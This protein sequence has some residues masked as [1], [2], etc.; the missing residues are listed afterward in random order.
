MCV[1]K[2]SNLVLAMCVIGSA[3][4]A[5]DLSMEGVVHA[6][7]LGNADLAAARFEVHK[8]EGRL[9][10]SG[11]LPNP[12]IE[13]LGLSDFASANQ[14]EGEI[15]VGLYQLFPLTS[16]LGISREIS[17][18]GVAEA[19]REIRNQE[20]LLIAK[21]QELYIRIQAAQM[22][23]QIAQSAGE[24]FHKYAAAAQE[25]LDSGQGSL[26]ESVM[27]RIETQRWRI[28]ANEAHVEAE[29]FLIELKTTLNL[30]ADAMLSLTE[31]LEDAVK[32]LRAR[33]QQS[34]PSQRPDVELQWLALD[35]AAAEA[36]LARASAWEGIRVGIE[37]KQD[38]SME[39]PEG[40]GTG[41]FFGVGVSL[42]LPVWDRKIGDRL[43]ADATA[44]Q[45]RVKIRALE[46]QVANAI[47]TA[48][49]QSD[50]YEGQWVLYGAESRPLIES[51]IRN[52]EAGFKDG[53][54][55]ATDVVSVHL[56]CDTL[57]HGSVEI[58][59][60]F[61]LSL[62]ELESVTG[63][64]PAINLPYVNPNSLRKTKNKK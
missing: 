57:S 1:I 38:K 19:L 35:R 29:N 39:E 6:A 21:V 5:A 25:R 64:H 33:L 55:E 15:N 3:S 28:L 14:G 60:N 61:A 4:E 8:A 41:N 50:L 48:K 46:L 47:A 44:E 22:R 45:Q 54:V 36:R 20:R 18:V 32:N 11:L 52:M 37:Y 30:P 27:A 53:R 23:Q 26:S 40:L 63:T 59:E 9:R 42:P 12:E 56:Q 49:K 62:V 24:D 7:L 34:R 16:R 58:L 10:S 43:A 51:A 31:S 17:R 2:I 13:F